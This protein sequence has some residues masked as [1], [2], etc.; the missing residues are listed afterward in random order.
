LFSGCIKLKFYSGRALFLLLWQRLLQ[1]FTSSQQCSHF[2][3]QAKGRR[4]TTQVFS[5]KLD[6]LYFLPVVRVF[7]FDFI[8]WSVLPF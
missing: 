4:Q 7:F 2:L 6:L 5:G 8:E 3:R 1:Y